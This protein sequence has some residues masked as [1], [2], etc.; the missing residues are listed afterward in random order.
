MAELPDIPHFDMPF[1]FMGLHPAVVAQDDVE[2]VMN[3]VE[4][5]FRTQPGERV[6]LPDFGIEDMTFEVQPLDLS[7]AAAVIFE[8]EP[9]AIMAFEQEP[10]RLDSM[11]AK[12]T[13]NIAQAE[14]KS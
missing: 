4:A 5:I 12:V 14:E 10:D 11:V 6:E 13:V 2:D 3:C 7:L 9:R 8:Q 1:R